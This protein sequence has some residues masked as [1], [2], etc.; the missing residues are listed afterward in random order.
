MNIIALSLEQVAG[1]RQARVDGPLSAIAQ[2]P[3]VH[4]QWGSGN[5]VI[6]PNTPAGVIMLH[7][8]FVEPPLWQGL[9]SLLTKGW[10]VTSDMDD[11]PAAWPGFAANDYLAYRG[12]HAVTVST[13]A[14]ATLIS[15]YNPNVHVLPNAI[16]NL[17]LSSN[18][19]LKVPG[20]VRIFFGALN[21]QLDWQPIIDNINAALI[22]LT[23]S[24]HPVHVMVVHDR[25][26]F[27]AVPESIPKYFHP[28]LTHE[29]YLQVLSTCD[30]A[31]LPL[32]DTP[33]NRLKSDLKFIECCAAGVVPIC[34]TVV[35]AQER[36]H[37]QIGIFPEANQWGQA[38]IDLCRDLQKIVQRRSAGLSYVLR[39]RL[40]EHQAQRRLAIYR[41]LL[42]N[43][44]VLEAQRQQRLRLAESHES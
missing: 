20:V 29:K 7:R 4:C 23:E 6:P 10:V 28:T 34:S 43:R 18:T 25:A 16:S 11:D 44:E 27:D 41:D 24:S 14:L 3:G 1:I 21:R 17:I 15:H 36:E 12:V 32:L 2:L 30:V 39:E 37:H 35:Y 40:H 31:L 9:Q 33:F 5:I 19:T 8:L 13:E 22:E 42:Q 26:F 38:L